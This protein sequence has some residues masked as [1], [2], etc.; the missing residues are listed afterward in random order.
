MSWDWRNITLP[1]MR[2]EWTWRSPAL[3]RDMSVCRWG[4][5]GKPVLIFPTA[6]GDY[7]ECERY[8]LI[9]SIKPLVEAGKIKVYA[10][11]SISGDGWLDSEAKPWHRTFLQARF[12]EYLVR[13]LCPFIKQESGDTASR[14]AAVGASLGA[15][16]ALNAATK[17][18]QWFDLAV[19]MS[20]T[21]DFKRWM[22]GHVDDN[23]YFNMPLHFLP[24]LGEGRQLELLR[25]SRF[26]LASGQGRAEAP[27]E[28]VW[29]ANIM[30]SKGIPHFLEIWGADVHHDWPTWRAMLPMFLDRLV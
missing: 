23:Y 16:N 24:N 1:E 20:G 8:M 26:L 17:H 14:F 21:Y 7:L 10:C 29:I 5:Y 27:W 19:C 30:K 3:D 18:P 11:G 15:Y 6:G 13:E 25:S 22:D 9:K 12:D 2:Q 28:S 4:F